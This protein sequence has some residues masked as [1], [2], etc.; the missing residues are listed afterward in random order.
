MLFRSMFCF[1]V[2]SEMSLYSFSKS[3]LYFFHRVQKHSVLR[4]HR[5]TFV[6]LTEV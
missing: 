1:G 6:S 5:N 2:C 3:P 4:T